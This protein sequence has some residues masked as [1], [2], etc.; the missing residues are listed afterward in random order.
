MKQQFRRAKKNYKV[1]VAAPHA[2]RKNQ[3]IEEYLKRVKS[4]TY[5]NY[6]ILLVDNSS[7]RKNY[8]MLIKHD[9]NV[10]YVKPKKK[11][12]QIFIA[13]SHEAIRKF[14]LERG[15][16]FVLHLETDVFPPH[17]IIERLLV[18]EKSVVS[19]PYMI[20][21][22]HN[23]HLMIQDIEDFGDIRETV[24]VDNG[25]D[26]LRVDGELQQVYSVGLGCSLIHRS[27]LEQ[28]TFRAQKGASPHPDS[29]FAMDLDAMQIPQ[30]L[31]TS[32]LCDH[33][34]TEWLKNPY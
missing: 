14:A 2:D 16:A 19:A 29:F 4:L 10:L 27:V 17:D 8:K 21:F 32:I 12:S 6:D 11:E 28:I 9:I 24:N 25:A 3:T 22:G 20:N 31:D 23:S 7:N 5:G 18:H 13:E 15:Y 26:F 33:R 1:L 34:N 30:Y